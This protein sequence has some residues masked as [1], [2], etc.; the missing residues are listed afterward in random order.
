MFNKISLKA[1]ILLGSA[2]TLVLMI[3]IGVIGNNG[4]NSLNKTSKWI[5]HTHVVIAEANDILASAVNMETGMRGFLLAGKVDFLNPYNSGKENFNKQIAALSNTVSDN[6]QQVR[7]LKE[8]K[9]NILAWQKDVTEPVIDLRKEIGDAKTMNDM[10][11][12]IAEAKG[13]KYFDRFRGQIKTFI[14]REERLMKGRKSFKMVDHTHKVIRKAMQ[15]EA[16]AVDMETGMRGFLLAGE[17]SFLE[18]FKAGK[19]NFDTLVKSLKRTVRDNP[20]QVKLL[21]QISANIHGWISNIVEVNINLRRNI[22]NAKTMDDMADIVGEARGKTYFDKFRSQI[23]TFIGRERSLME[24]RQIDAVAKSDSV[25]SIT[26]ITIVVSVI[27]AIVIALVL[28]NSIT[29]PIRRIFQ[30]LK[31]FS[32]A[33]LDDV[34]AKFSSVVIKLSNGSQVVSK[35][36]DDMANG[37]TSQAAT[38]EET[39]A[40]VEEIAAVINT[41]STKTN[42]VNSLMREVNKVV[43]NANKFM[44]DLIESMEGISSA[45]NEISKI[46]K[47]I[48]EIASQ[49]K[50]L[51]LNAAVEAARA[52]E[53]GLGFAVVAEEVKSLAGR[54]AQAAQET[55]VLIEGNVTKVNNGSE[56]VEQTSKAFKEV[57]EYS[58][59]ATTLIA[60][61]SNASNEQSKGI[62][63]INSAVSNLDQTV[64]ASAANTEELSSQAEDLNSQVNILLEILEGKKNSASSNISLIAHKAE[65]HSK[66]DFLES[67]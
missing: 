17:E 38:L 8:I 10:A 9:E 13:K 64:Q 7:L 67:F 51:A 21:T 14:Q 18:P 23:E 4:I 44:N 24:Q 28:S 27:I 40:S 52:G 50:L 35:A 43:N 55:G 34:S 1:K 36:S 26:I 30:G 48:D 54:S 39:S 46:I 63:Q 2:V 49:T 22:G 37:A 62:A 45:S 41:S 59:K 53:H 47:T 11:K 65:N 32:S 29:N 56:L 12:V 3:V 58:E 61:V 16:A 15:I 33:E 25:K 66:E 31:L 60:D 42:E 6:P 5:N 19:K 20:A 57:L